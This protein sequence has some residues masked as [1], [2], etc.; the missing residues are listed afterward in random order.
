[1]LWILVSPNFFLWKRVKYYSRCAF[2]ECAAGYTISF[3]LNMSHCQNLYRAFQLPDST[4]WVVGSLSLYHLFP[5]PF[6]DDFSRP[7]GKSL[8]KACR[9]G[10]H[11]DNNPFLLFP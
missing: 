3:T 11:A 10:E 8:L 9:K 7:Q 1:M 5:L 2:D 4:D 6:Y